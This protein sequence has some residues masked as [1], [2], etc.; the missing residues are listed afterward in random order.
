[1]DLD[2]ILDTFRSRLMPQQIDR[3]KI[4]SYNASLVCTRELTSRE[5]RHVIYLSATFQTQA[6]A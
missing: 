3:L 4:G 1:M 2:Q 5:E 6:Q